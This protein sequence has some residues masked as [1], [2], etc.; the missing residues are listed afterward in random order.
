M[1]KLGAFSHHA[2]RKC[3]GNAM[4]ASRQ[5]RLEQPCCVEFDVIG[6]RTQPSKVA[7]PLNCDK[8]IVTTLFLFYVFGLVHYRPS[9]GGDHQA[10]GAI[11][12]YYW[13]VFSLFSFS[14]STDKHK[15]RPKYRCYQQDTFSLHDD[16]VICR[17]KQTMQLHQMSLRVLV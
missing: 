10:R 12:G 16:G 15:N 7:A 5:S 17:K 11:K 3:I 6:L 13:L 4:A 1:R 8:A 14:L 9:R 2:F